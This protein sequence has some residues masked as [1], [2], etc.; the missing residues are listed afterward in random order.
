MKKET[1]KPESPA[2]Q[3]HHKF[4]QFSQYQCNETQILYDYLIKN[5]ATA[6]MVSAATRI[7]QKGICQYKRELEKSDLLWKVNLIY[8][9]ITGF[10]VAYLTANPSSSCTQLS[11][12][13]GSEGCNE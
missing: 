5:I 4:N 13:S 7:V 8:C 11:L 1:T 6:S 10:K 3:L 2:V 12:F 9:K